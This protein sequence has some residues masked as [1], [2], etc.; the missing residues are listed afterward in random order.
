[1]QLSEIHKA[2][3]TISVARVIIRRGRENPHHKRKFVYDDEVGEDIPATSTWSAQ[4]DKTIAKLSEAGVPFQFPHSVE[5]LLDFTLF[6][7][8]EESNFNQDRIKH[9]H[10]LEKELAHLVNTADVDRL[11][12]FRT[13]LTRRLMQ[14][15]FLEILHSLFFHSCFSPTYLRDFFI[16]PPPPHFS[17]PSTEDTGGIGV[18][19]LEA[20]D[21]DP[22]DGQSP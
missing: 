1:M 4:V 10:A 18:E 16:R 11:V 15:R 19:I 22:D 2:I 13:H 12:E 6:D 9:S 17:R 20:V 14:V 5:I 21:G 7:V 3:L 8:D